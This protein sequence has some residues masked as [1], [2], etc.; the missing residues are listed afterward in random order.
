MDLAKL[1]K[2]TE[3]GTDPFNL[4]AA[5]GLLGLP[6]EL[7][8]NMAIPELQGHISSGLAVIMLVQAWRDED[9]P[10]PY[11]LDREDGHY[12]VAIGYDAD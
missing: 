4:M 12:V 6:P 5:I 1:A 3:D 8:E 2:T 11:P 9:D 10:T 7:N